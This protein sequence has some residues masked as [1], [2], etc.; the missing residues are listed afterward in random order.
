MKLKQFVNP[1]TRSGDWY[2]ANLH[3][4]TTTSDGMLSPA[5]RVAQYRK[6][7]YD[8]LALTDH[9][10]TNDVRGMSDEKMLVI[11]GIEYH[12]ARPP[13][14][15]PYYHLVA[16]NVPHP[17][18][19][20][21][22]DDPNRCIRKIAKAGGLTILAHPYWCGQ[23]FADFKDLKGLAAMEVYNSTCARMGRA[24]S[25]NEWSYAL[26][27]DMPLPIIGVDDTHLVDSDDVFECW[28]W[29]KMPRPTVAN[30]LKAVRTGACYASCGPT[31]HDF[32]VEDGKITLRCSP[33]ST[34]HF[35]GQ[36][37][38]GARRRAEKGKTVKTFTI[39][40]YD[41]PYVRAVVTAPDGSKAWTNPIFL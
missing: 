16:L 21:N 11:S 23:S 18:E 33:V 3:T 9:R 4:H 7:G 24:C 17:L 19:I 1:F 37:P 8:V 22:G 12:P 14:E 29:L 20:E 25:E 34:I 27:H 40:K 35:I 30:V 38:H 26:A 13:A 6:A 28:T 2:K 15:N 32:R 10:A 31:I 5:D 36:A 39:P 41:W